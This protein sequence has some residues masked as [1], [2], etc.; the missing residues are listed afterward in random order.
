[1]LQ[2]VFLKLLNQSDFFPPIDL[3][4]VLMIELKKIKSYHLFLVAAKSDDKNDTAK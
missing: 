3:Y 2:C 1:M 4:A